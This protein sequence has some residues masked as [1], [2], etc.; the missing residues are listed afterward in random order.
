MIARVEAEHHTQAREQGGRLSLLLVEDSALDAELIAARLE[1]GGLLFELLR[2]DSAESFNAALA[3]HRFDLI[4]SDYKIPGFDGLSALDTCHRTC[5]EVPFLFVSGALG[6]ERAIELLKRGAT[7]Y[8]LK[9]RLDRL[10]PSIERALREARER[11]DRQRAEARLQEREHTLSTL[12]A[13]LP[14]MAFR[15]KVKDRPWHLDFASQ[16]C[17]DLTGWPPESFATGGEI[18]WD[19]IIHPEDLERMEREVR[20]ALAERRQLSISYRIR[21]RGG[22]ERWLWSRSLPRFAPDGSPECFEGFVTDITQQ[23]QAEEEVKRRIEF[24]QQLI[25]IVSHDL[26][27]PLTAIIFGASVLLKREGLDEKVTSSARR[28]LASA[29]RAGRMIRDLLDFTQARLGGIPVARAPLCL[30]AQASQVIDELGHTHP[31]RGLELTREGDTHGEWDPDRIA[32][33][34]SNLVGNALKYSPPDSVVRVRTRGERNVVLLEVHN[35]GEP[36]PPALIPELFKPLNRGTAR[37]DMQTRSIGLGLYIVDNIVRAHGGSVH[38][39]S[40]AA[41]GTIFTVRLP[42]S[43]SSA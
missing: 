41:E 7:D 10:V 39:S 42:R 17:L 30:H 25:G 20:A 37:T 22:E 40:T 18:S 29:E 43:P 21:T 26:R 15:R 14:G 1:E 36:I 31:E 3:E 32:Q 35:R 13:N 4:L 11:M 12:M 9:D 23:K 19:R 5:P 28:I 6:E 34:I 27:N 2:V 33:V 8:V 24:E 16:G 38:V